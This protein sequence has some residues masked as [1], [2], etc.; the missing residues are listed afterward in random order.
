MRAALYPLSIL[1]GAVTAARNGRYD[2]NIAAVYRSP[3]PVISVGNITAGG[4]GKTPLVIYLAGFLK[5]NGYS[6]VILSRGYKGRL[7][8]PYQVKAADRVE[9]CG[10]EPVLMASRGLNVVIAKDRAEGAK[11][12][13]AGKLG[14]AIILDDGFQH[15]RVARDIDIVNIYSGTPEAV[16]AFRKGDLLPL[17]RFREDR[18]AALK[19]A[20]IVIFSARQ[21][22]MEAAPPPELASL[23]PADK[24]VFQ[25]CFKFG[26]ISP[27]V[28]GGSEP[29]K[30]VAAVCAIANPHGFTE[31]LRSAGYEVQGTRFFPDHYR[32][33]IGDILRIKAGFSGLPVVMTEKDAVR[34]R[35]L[36]VDLKGFF[37]VSGGT[38]IGPE[39]E[40]QEEVLR[41]LNERR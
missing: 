31:T 15:R 35:Q 21:P 28:P 6:P 30:K 3:L 19:R 33:T 22:V 13:E 41:R 38:E 18:D 26:G 23:I 25:S 24:R 27:L 40:F 36:L 5:Q 39:G 4:T 11:F 29:E 37:F 32:F 17:G 16:E 9:D 20:D 12:I 7:K 2:R 34:V 10:D 1:Y 14:T 8:G